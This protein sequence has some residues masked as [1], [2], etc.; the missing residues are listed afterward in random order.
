MNVGKDFSSPGKLSCGVPRGSILGPILLLY[1]N[2]MPQ[3]VNSDILLYANDTCLIYT[4]KDIKTIEEQ[5]NTDFSSLCDWFIDNK[6]SVHFGDGKTK[7]ILFGTKRQLKHQGDL[8]LRYGDI[9]IKQHSKVT[10]LGC[11]L[12]NNLENLWPQKYLA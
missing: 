6:V 10:Y 12:D 8:E 5:L 7:S 2:D 9:E 11:M 1:V 4:D 3:A